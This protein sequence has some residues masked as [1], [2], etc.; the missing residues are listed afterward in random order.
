MGL[1]ARTFFCLL[2]VASLCPAAPP[3]NLVVEGVPE[4]PATLIAE[5]APYMNLGG[6]SFR[7]WHSTRREIIVSTRTGDASHLHLAAA[8]LAKRLPLTHGVEPV[9]SGWMQPGGKLLLYSID[10]G[11]SENFQ[12]YLQDTEDLKAKAI[13]LTDG[14][15]RNTDPV[16]SK[17][18]RL[19][20]YASNRRNGKD[21]DIV[22][23]QADATHRSESVV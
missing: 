20:A 21:R 1:P 11:G 15:S 16:W 5:L 17:D 10:V 22:V 3:A 4:A 9:K 8:P 2:A 14:K 13:L 18:G 23:V 6:A 7:G 12:L 19:I